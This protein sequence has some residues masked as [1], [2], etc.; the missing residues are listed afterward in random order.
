MTG[1]GKKDT[2]QV[3]KSFEAMPRYPAVI[4]QKTTA[5]AKRTNESELLEK[6]LFRTHRPAW[7][8]QR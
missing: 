2:K 8:R 4:M 5:L 1:I 7:A 6:A 3:S